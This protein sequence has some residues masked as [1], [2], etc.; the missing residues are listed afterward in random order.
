VQPVEITGESANAL[1][2][3]LANQTNAA[4]EEVTATDISGLAG[5]AGGAVSVINNTDGNGRTPVH[6]M[7]D[8]ASGLFA[9]PNPGA[10]VWVFFREGNPLFPVYFAASYSSAEWQSAYRGSGPG[11]QIDFSNPGKVATEASH[12]KPSSAL[13]I[14]TRKRT[15][16]DDP[17]DN[18]SVASISHEHGSG[19]HFKNGCDFFRSAAN[20][21]DEVDQDRHIVTRGYKDEWTQGDESKNTRGD[22]IIK[23]GNISQEAIDAM[24]ELSEMS[25]KMNQMLKEK[26]TA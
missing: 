16:L 12:F 14:S 15:N 10:M 5:P 18:E 11:N 7:N 25:Y 17:L 19:I 20:R 22:S 23:I 1:K 26:P 8:M 9:F 24:N 21:R 6:N 4:L 13:A 3:S 2:Q